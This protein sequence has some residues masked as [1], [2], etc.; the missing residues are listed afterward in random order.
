MEQV[1]CSY[2]NKDDSIG[3]AS[4]DLQKYSPMRQL[5]R[6]KGNSAG[7]YDN[8]ISTAFKPSPSQEVNSNTAVE[9]IKYIWWRRGRGGLPPTVTFQLY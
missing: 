2:H 6:L 4:K 8:K 3:Q 5:V 9:I 7:E 1:R